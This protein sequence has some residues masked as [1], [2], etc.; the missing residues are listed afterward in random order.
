MGV[1]QA[2]KLVFK[3]IQ[4]SGVFGALPIVFIIV[5]FICQTRMVTTKSPVILTRLRPS[6]THL[7]IFASLTANMNLTM[8]IRKGKSR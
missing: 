3:K 2:N 7:D 6:D 8:A 4:E 1:Q 5:I